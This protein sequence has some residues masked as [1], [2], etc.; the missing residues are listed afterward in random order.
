MAPWWR[1]VLCFSLFTPESGVDSAEAD[2]VGSRRIRFCAYVPVALDQGVRHRRTTPG[3]QFIP[4]Y[5]R[6][7]S[8]GLFAG[9]GSHRTT[10]HRQLAGTT[11]SHTA[12]TSATSHERAARAH[13][14]P[15]TAAERH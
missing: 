11:D 10:G 14:S 1:R 4:F 8:P 2:K 12:G 9:C 3:A 15:A 13:V 5:D 6:V 7:S